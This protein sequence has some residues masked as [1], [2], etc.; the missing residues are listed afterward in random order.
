MTENASAFEE[1]AAELYRLSPQ[2]FVAARDAQAAR[3][4]EAGQLELAAQLRALRRPA[5]GAWL[6]NLL[7]REQRDTVESLL[8]LGAELRAAQQRLSGAELRELSAQRHRVVGSL[9]S[10]ARRLAAGAGVRVTADTAREVEN[11]LNA[12][13]ASDEVADEVRSGRL[14]KPV[15]YAG[16]G[17]GL[18]A[19]GRAAQGGEPARGVRPAAVPG[20]RTAG[21]EPRADAAG[22]AA[23]QARKAVAAAGHAV[24]EARTALTEAQQRL[25]SASAEL[26][27]AVRERDEL[28]ER[29]AELREQVRD[30]ERRS[31]AAELDVRAAARRHQ[32]AE[33][34]QE[35]AAQRLKRAEERLARLEPASG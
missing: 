1:A 26:E 21:P 14:V 6:V 16:F 3:A 28:R 9:V 20:P 19:G 33:S 10:E 8:A 32:Q 25:E 12:A 30:L 31:A 17:P 35:A 5:Q 11:T 29:L 13:L 22:E 2:E 23:A 24:A 18:P 7:W 34:A 27:E 15:E 4:R